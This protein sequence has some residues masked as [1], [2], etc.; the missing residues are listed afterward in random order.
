MISRCIIAELD[1]CDSQALTLRVSI[2]YAHVPI[3]LSTKLHCVPGQVESVFELPS[4]EKSTNAEH[5]FLMIYWWFLAVSEIFCVV[6]TNMITTPWNNMKTHFSG[7]DNMLTRNSSLFRKPGKKQR[8]LVVFV[9]A[10]NLRR[11]YSPTL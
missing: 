7:N 3:A 9:A 8:Y 11:I 6:P 2:F 10:V 5:N 4:S 1:H